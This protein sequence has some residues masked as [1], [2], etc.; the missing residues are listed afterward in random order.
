[1]NQSTAAEICLLMRSVT[2]RT[3]RLLRRYAESVL[4]ITDRVV[5]LMLLDIAAAN[6]A[7]EIRAMANRARAQ[8]GK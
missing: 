7:D 2:S 1:M 8:I 3:E 4:G 6:A 5:R